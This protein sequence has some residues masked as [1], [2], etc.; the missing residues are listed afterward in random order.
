M[1]VERGEEAIV[2]KILVCPVTAPGAFEA[3][4]RSCSPKHR[5]GARRGRVRG[6]NAGFWRRISSG[7]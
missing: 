2:A 5:S 7:T 3:T 1:P 4:V 6:G